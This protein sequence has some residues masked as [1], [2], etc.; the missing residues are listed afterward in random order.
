[1][2]WKA[3]FV[4]ALLC[5]LAFTAKAH[6]AAWSKGMYCMKGLPGKED[7]D[8]MLPV[9][10]QYML[11][12]EDWWF[13]HDRGCD[14]VPPPAGHY[15]ELPAGGSFTVEIAQNRAFTTFGKNSKFNGYYGG[16]QQLKRGDEECVIDPNLHTP[17]QALAPGT[18]FAI[19]YQ[20][21]I[22]NVTPENLVVF[23]VRYHTPW[24][25]L[26]S[27]DVP[28]DLPPCPPGGCTCAW[29]R[30]VFVIALVQDEIFEEV[31]E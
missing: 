3:I 12:K 24:Q 26:T 28:K 25:R 30:L 2:L 9:Y 29:G 11:T 13:Q 1:M 6:Q 22:D 5:A 20:N 27:Y 18:V 8:N 23:T 15:L 31:L 19:S 14:K 10:P 17:S 4:S 7:W 21:S 16:P